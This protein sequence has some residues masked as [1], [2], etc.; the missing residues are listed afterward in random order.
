MIAD[1]GSADERPALSARCFT[2]VKYLAERSWPWEGALLGEM[3]HT[4]E[5]P[6]GGALGRQEATLSARCFTRVKRTGLG[7]RPPMLSARCFTHVKDLVE[8]SWPW[9][10]ALSARCFTRVKDLAERSRPPRGALS[11]ARRVFA[12]LFVPVVEGEGDG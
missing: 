9:E 5:G 6:R 8:R 7:R 3:L 2:H 4:C 1:G 11:A 12:Q 10:V